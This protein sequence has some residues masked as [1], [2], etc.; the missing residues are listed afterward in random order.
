MVDRITG[1]KMRI[2]KINPALELVEPGYFSLST[3]T[4]QGGLMQLTRDESGVAVSC[5]RQVFHLPVLELRY[6]ACS[7]TNY[8]KQRISEG[9]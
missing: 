4:K 9:R 7:H 8:T 2:G 6:R 1:E 3:S 5:F